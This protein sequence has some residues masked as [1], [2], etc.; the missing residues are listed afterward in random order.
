MKNIT[1]VGLN[2]TGIEVSPIDSKELLAIT[3]QVP[4]D[5]AGNI[6][7]L[8]EAR[9][10]FVKEADAIGSVPIP[11]SVAGLVKAAGN[12]LMGRHQEVFIDKIGERLAFELA[13]VRLYDAMLA[14]AQATTDSDPQLLNDLNHF[15]AE[16]LEHYNITVA[17][18]RALS[19]DPTTQTPCA[20]TVSVASAGILK[21]IV[22]PRTNLSQSLNA[23][24]SAELIDNVGWDLL[25]E[26]AEQTNQEESMINNFKK[27]LHQECDHLATIK[28]WLE[29]SVLGEA[30]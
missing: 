22:D 7:T 23:L 19:A 1:K 16:E 26:L 20:D 11:G 28:T 29:K 10:V 2:R 21:V 24:L 4:P 8:T 14:K 17:A 15:R 12:K 27:A 25:I 18:L 9:T 6:E 3:Q 13:G 5:V 30:A